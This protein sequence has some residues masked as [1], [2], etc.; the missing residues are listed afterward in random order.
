MCQLKF[1]DELWLEIHV[2]S[3]FNPTTSGIGG[4]GGGGAGGNDSIFDSTNVNLASSESGESG[5][6]T[7]GALGAIA[8][9]STA[10]TSMFSCDLKPPRSRTNSASSV[11][12]NVDENFEID[13]MITL[14]ECNMMMDFD[15]QSGGSVGNKNQNGKFVKIY[16]IFFTFDNFK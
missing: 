10:K 1:K 13:Q 2:D 15:D 11:T 12:A 14:S 8:A 16:F 5:S 9:A 4:G 3:H 6:V 7:S